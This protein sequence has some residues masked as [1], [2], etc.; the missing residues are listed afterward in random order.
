MRRV[1]T[2][3]RFAV[4]CTLD[5]QIFSATLRS[6]PLEGRGQ[7]VAVLST[8]DAINLAAWLIVSAREAVK[9]NNEAV[10]LGER[11]RDVLDEVRELVDAI[12]AP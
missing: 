10:R 1:D 2:H 5:G 12:E 7:P 3:N 9:R 11:P 6:R 4:G 8:N